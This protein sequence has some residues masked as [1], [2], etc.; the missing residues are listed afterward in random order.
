MTDQFNNIQ[1]GLRASK[2]LLF[3]FTN[4]LFPWQNTS[5]QEHAIEMSSYWRRWD[6]ITSHR[7]QYDIIATF[8]GTA[9]QRRNL[10]F[11]S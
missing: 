3:Y 8:C 6:I 1:W 11:F 10:G 2:I 7:R 9:L 5:Q 4:H